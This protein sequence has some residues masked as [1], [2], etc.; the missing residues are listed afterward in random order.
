M[1]CDDA[2]PLA[3]AAFDSG[4]ASILALARDGGDKL[5]ANLI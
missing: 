1:A 4:G 2:R 3:H 5:V